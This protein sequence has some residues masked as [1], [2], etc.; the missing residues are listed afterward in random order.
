MLFRS[1]VPALLQALDR[2][3]YGCSEQVVSRAMPLLYVNKLAATTGTDFSYY[4]SGSL[5]IDSVGGVNGIT[6]GGKIWVRTAA[7]LT[8]VQPVVGNGAGNQAVVLAA[9]DYGSPKGANG[10]Y[11]AQV[12][13]RATD[14]SSS[15]P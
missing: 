1:D 5:G 2:Y 7:N 12:N 13:G 9:K 14:S 3:P 10:Y 6:A 11:V 8:T 15:I 4:D